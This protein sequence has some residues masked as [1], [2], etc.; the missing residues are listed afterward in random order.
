MQSESAL[1]AGRAYNAR[2]CYGVEAGRSRDFL[3]GNVLKLD[4][5]N[6]PEIKHVALRYL[7]AYFKVNT[8]VGLVFDRD[9][10]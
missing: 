1:L 3:Q 9:M 8:W 6:N 7:S 2:N 5:M 4:S 10:A